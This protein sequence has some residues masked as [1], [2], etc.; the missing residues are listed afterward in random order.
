MTLQE[1]NTDPMPHAQSLDEKDQRDLRPSARELAD[2]EDIA[3]VYHPTFSLPVTEERLFG[4]DRE[5]IDIERF[6]LLPEVGHEPTRK[7]RK[8]SHL[9]KS[10]EKTLFLRYNYAKYRLARCKPKKD[11]TDDDAL[12]WATRAVI[13]RE[14]LAHANLPLVPTMA[15]RMSIPGVEFSEMVSEGYMAVLRSIEK[16]DIGRGYKFSTY[17]CR[18][19]LSSFYRLGSKAKT[20]RK[21]IPTY[22][23]KA[24][25]KSDFP[26]QRH[27]HERSFAAEAVRR[28]LS[29]NLA[30]LSETESRIIQE[31]YPAIPGRKGRTLAQVGELVG[32]SNER[33]RQ[34][35]KASLTKLRIAIEEEF[36]GAGVE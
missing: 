32:L 18:A 12:K 27:E 24:M 9:S 8:K 26:E 2:C 13:V 5:E 23:D 17:A 28:V 1:R 31:R 30:D 21:H 29:K 14:Q 20:R 10:Q 15:R 22:F 25:E 19:I 35:E 16:F 11:P 7:A 6:G 36:R 33:V 4:D 34:I 3:Y